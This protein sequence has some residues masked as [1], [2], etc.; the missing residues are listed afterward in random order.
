MT[1]V[2]QSGLSIIIPAT[3][4]FSQGLFRLYLQL[5]IIVY[6]MQPFQL[7]VMQLLD[8]MRE[9]VLYPKLGPFTFGM[10]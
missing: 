8:Q 4:I 2:K 7:H 10:T 1:G 9:I 3:A 5:V 6:T